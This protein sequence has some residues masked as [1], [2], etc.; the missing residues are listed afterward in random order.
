MA[1]IKVKDANGNGKLDWFDVFVYCVSTG[2]NAA[3]TAATII[4]MA[5]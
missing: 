1:K 3:I 2:L 4:S 5:V